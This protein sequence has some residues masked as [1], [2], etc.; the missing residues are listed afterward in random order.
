[1]QGELPAL[2]VRC[3][4]DRLTF[5]NMLY[6]YARFFG[7]EGKLDWLYGDSISAAFSYRDNFID[8]YTGER[9]AFAEPYLA[10]WAHLCD[11]DLSDLPTDDIERVS[12]G[13]IF[14]FL[15]IVG[16]IVQHE[17]PRDSLVEL[18]RMLDRATN[19]YIEEGGDP[20]SLLYK[21]IL[22]EREELALR[23]A[24]AAATP[25]PPELLTKTHTKEDLFRALV[26]RASRAT[27]PEPLVT[28]AEAHPDLSEG[29]REFVKAVAYASASAKAFVN[30]IEVPD[31][32]DIINGSSQTVQMNSLEQDL[33]ICCLRSFAKF[34]LSSAPFDRPSDLYPELDTEVL[35]FCFNQ[36]NTTMPGLV[37]QMLGW[38]TLT[39]LGE[40][41]GSFP[42]SRLSAVEEIGLS[43]DIP[44][45]LL[46]RVADV[47]FQTD[48]P[49]RSAVVAA[50]GSEG[51]VGFVMAFVMERRFKEAGSFADAHV[52]GRVSIYE[53]GRFSFDPTDGNK[54]SDWPLSGEPFN[55]F[56]LPNSRGG[57]ADRQ[58]EERVVVKPI[59]SALAG[60]NGVAD[61]EQNA[62][63]MVAPIP[64]GSPTSAAPAS[65]P[66]AN[67]T[68]A[69]GIF[70]GVVGTLI[71]L[72]WCSSQLGQTYQAAATTPPA[73]SAPRQ[74]PMIL[75]EKASTSWGGDFQ[76]TIPQ[77][78]FTDT[79][80]V[81]VDINYANA[82][83]GDWVLLTLWRNG[84][85]ASACPAYTLTSLPSGVY[86]CHWPSLPAGSYEAHVAFNGGDPAPGFY[87]FT[88]TQS[89][90]AP[91]NQA[92]ATDNAT[93][94]STAQATQPAGDENT[95]EAAGK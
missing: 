37:Q 41:V 55:D 47:R 17:L 77:T 31:L 23:C 76:S 68:K 59:E 51:G 60:E 72:A 12:L 63:R 45:D 95:A 56:R 8:Q 15:K 35:D 16:D 39:I 24:E 70:G 26:S 25:Q 19:K 20:S 3:R 80:P 90:P 30:R 32:V 7:I 5:E 50:S 21:R 44:E 83:A 48:R 38:T 42:D 69:I 67:V 66:P 36:A 89:S 1:M 88:V 94:N 33:A 9:T 93:D 13:L 43:T 79:Q 75:N 73:A 29:E 62:L 6:D 28:D 61:E 4:Q 65:A 54:L 18:L 40:D 2:F 10:L 86:G 58:D 34:Q 82:Q 52:Y 53:D 74:P 85:Q 22:R 81:N 71:L 27:S 46:G 91:A 78:E 11:R 84:A 87:A 49:C 57:V 14:V 92:V 64:V